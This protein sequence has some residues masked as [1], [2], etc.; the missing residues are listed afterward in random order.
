MKQCHL[1]CVIPNVIAVTNTHTIVA[2]KI[3]A[4]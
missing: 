4:R 2:T 3:T 1:C